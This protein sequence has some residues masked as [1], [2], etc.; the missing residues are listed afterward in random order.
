MMDAFELR[1]VTESLKDIMVECWFLFTPK[2]IRMTN[3]D[4]EKVIMTE[5]YVNLPSEKYTCPVEFRFPI[6][7]HTLY[8]LLRTAKRGETVMLQSDTDH[9]YI[10]IS[11]FK[12]NGDLKTQS[13]ISPLTTTPDLTI[14]NAIIY[15]NCFSIPTLELYR[16]I[17]EMVNF[18]RHV[19]MEIE[20][21][22]LDVH[23]QDEMKTF[24]RSSLP[25]DDILKT[26]WEGT[27]LGRYIEKFCKSNL[28]KNVILR[29]EQNCPMTISYE[30]EYGHLSMSIASLA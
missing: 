4:P 25:C 1:M 3:V 14:R 10:C 20:N 28:R 11:V 21:G 26:R 12:E 19:T 9:A 24:L 18:S 6:Y 17:H 23:C 15:K 13:R 29:V 5:Y 16:V 2:F 8:R 22:V 30:L 7:I 27:F